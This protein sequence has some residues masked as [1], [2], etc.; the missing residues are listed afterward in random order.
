M[1]ATTSASRLQN[2]TMSK[3]VCTFEDLDEQEL[4]RLRHRGRANRCN[5]CLADEKKWSSWRKGEWRPIFTRST[6]PQPECHSDVR[7]AN[8]GARTKGPSRTM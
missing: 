6:W 3:S 8:F 2:Q 5:T 7:Y 4:K 1:L